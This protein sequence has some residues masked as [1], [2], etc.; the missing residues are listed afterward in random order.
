MSAIKQKAD[1]LQDDVSSEC[2]LDQGITK[3]DEWW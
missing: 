2:R 3:C 1:V